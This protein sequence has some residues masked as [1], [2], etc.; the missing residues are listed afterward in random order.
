[1]DLVGVRRCSGRRAVL[2]GADAGAQRRWRTHMVV[3][4]LDDREGDRPLQRWL[5]PLAF[6]PY[7]CCSLSAR[8]PQQLELQR[9]QSRK[10]FQAVAVVVAADHRY[11]SSFDWQQEAMGN[12]LGLT[13]QASR[14]AAP[15]DRL[16]ETTQEVAAVDGGRLPVE[17]VEASRLGRDFETTHPTDHVKRTRETATWCVLREKKSQRELLVHYQSYEKTIE[18]RCPGGVSDR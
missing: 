12:L 6:A 7:A 4:L 16:V 5:G 1:M 11:L 15:C 18:H 17:A 8:A 2:A 14:S 9:C 13:D 3:A 10:A